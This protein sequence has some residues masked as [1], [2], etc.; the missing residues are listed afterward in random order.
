VSTEAISSNAPTTQTIYD[1]DF[2]PAHALN[3]SDNG[4]PASYLC[5]VEHL[6]PTPRTVK[7]RLNDLDQCL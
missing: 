3:V 7:K 1:F 2:I 6:Q 5:K 4:F